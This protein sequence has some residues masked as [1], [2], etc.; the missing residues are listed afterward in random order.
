[1]EKHIK[2]LDWVEAVVD[3]V[4]WEDEVT[5]RR[6]DDLRAQRVALKGRGSLATSLKLTVQDIDYALRECNGN[7]LHAADF[8]GVERSLLKRKVDLNPALQRTMLNLQEEN[9]D[10][11]EA[12]LLEQVQEGHFPAVSF[13]LRTI[14]KH[15]GYSE[16]VVNEYELGENATRTAAALID[17]M[18]KGAGERETVVVVEPRKELT[19]DD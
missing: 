11:A 4:E 5:K 12:K 13:Y 15:R 2:E 6:F 18:R 8:L 7:L 9:I 1:M 17:A 14:G 16:R 19:V 3:K 10:K